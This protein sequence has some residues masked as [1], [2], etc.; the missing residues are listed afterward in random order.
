MRMILLEKALVGMICLT[1][2]FYIISDDL[3]SEHDVH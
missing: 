3:A 2:S 1:Y